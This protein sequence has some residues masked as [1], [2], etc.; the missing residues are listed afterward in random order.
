MG[1]I[2]DLPDPRDYTYRHRSV[3]PLLEELNRDDQTSPPAEVDLRRVCEEEFLPPP[4]DQRRLNT[5]TAFAALSL[6][7]YFERRVYGRTF[8]GSAL[9]LYQITRNRLHKQQQPGDTGADLRTTFKMLTNVG[10]PPEDQ[11]PYDEQNMEQQPSPFLYSI[12]CRPTEAIYLRLDEP[13]STGAATWETVTSFLAAGFPVAFGFAVP[14]SLNSDAN[15][16]FRPETGL[17]P[18]RTSSCGGRF[19]TRPFRPEW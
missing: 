19:Q 6:V 15:I 18:W 11:W 7:E 10:V 14:S 1:W 9:F 5:S 8:E 12:T 3:I 17:H 4:E 13:N 16:L 2:P